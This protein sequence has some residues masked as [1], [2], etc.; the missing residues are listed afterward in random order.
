VKIAGTPVVVN[1]CA[2]AQTAGATAASL[3]DCVSIRKPR[4]GHVVPANTGASAAGL[5]SGVCAARQRN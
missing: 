5:R 2:D 4:H 1:W 3:R